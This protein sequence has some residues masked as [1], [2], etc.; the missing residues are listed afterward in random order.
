MWLWLIR[1]VAP[2]L[3]Y[4]T[5]SRLAK[6]WHLLITERRLSAVKVRG[7]RPEMHKNHLDTMSIPWDEIATLEIR[8][9]LLTNSVRISSKAKEGYLFSEYAENY[10]FAIARGGNDLQ[11][12]K[13]AAQTARPGLQV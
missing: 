8:K 5:Q 6:T 1:L 11:A 10:R 13:E 12:L 4:V 9:G 3:Y 7:P 2:P